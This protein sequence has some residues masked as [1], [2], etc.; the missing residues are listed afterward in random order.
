MPNWIWL[1]PVRLKALQDLF[2]LEL[3]L[4]RSEY[5]VE[6]IEDGFR[7]KIELV[8]FDAF[9]EAVI[10]ANDEALK[11]IDTIEGLEYSVND[12]GLIIID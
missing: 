12:D 7:Q 1:Y 8:L 6:K 4:F 9:R 11:L 2:F 10:N 5:I 3:E